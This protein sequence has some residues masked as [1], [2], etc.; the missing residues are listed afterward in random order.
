MSA[1]SGGGEG[2]ELVR[3]L[4]PVALEQKGSRAKLALL[5]IENGGGNRQASAG[6]REPA[7]AL[8]APKSVKGQCRARNKSE[9]IELNERRGCHGLLE[10]GGRRDFC[11]PLASLL[12]LRTRRLLFWSQMR[13]RRSGGTRFLSVA[14]RRASVT[15]HWGKHELG[16]HA[17]GTRPRSTKLNDRHTAIKEV[18]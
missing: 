6:P 17:H 8:S 14:G 5:Q 1:R 13:G 9:P 15:K 4:K 10:V 3:G 12:N 7:A 16:F 11:A 18:K 2:R